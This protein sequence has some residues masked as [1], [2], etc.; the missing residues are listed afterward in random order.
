M[1]FSLS[2]GVRTV[3]LPLLLAGF[4]T[5][6][7]STGNNQNAKQVK[8][9]QQNSSTCVS[10]GRPPVDNAKQC[11]LKANQGDADAMWRLAQLLQQHGPNTRNPNDA[12]KMLQWKDIGNSSQA[13]VWINQAAKAGSIDA[14]KYKCSLKDD[15]RAP[16]YMRDQAPH[17]CDQLKKAH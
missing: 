12:A 7:G 15:V 10:V 17:W 5:A 8:S 4:L 13:V 9:N 16:K 11:L 1:S 6:C 14:M 3:A 2:H